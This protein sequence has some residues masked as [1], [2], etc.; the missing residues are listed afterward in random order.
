MRLDH[1]LGLMLGF[2]ITGIAAGVAVLPW[3]GASSLSASYARRIVGMMLLGGGLALSA[4]AIGL[5]NAQ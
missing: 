1:G 2:G 4:F 5:G 3:R